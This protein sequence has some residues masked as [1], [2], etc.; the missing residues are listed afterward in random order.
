VHERFLFCTNGFIF[1][2]LELSRYEKYGKII[3][4]EQSCYKVVSSRTQK[5]REVVLMELFTF[6][7][8]VLFGTFLITLLAYIDRNNKH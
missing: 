2:F 7:D 1:I 4:M 5:R 8:L 6:Q 3:F